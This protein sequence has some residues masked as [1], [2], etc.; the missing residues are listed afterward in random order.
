M[1]KKYQTKMGEKMG[2]SVKEIVNLNFLAVSK[3]RMYI[4]RTYD[5]IKSNLYNGEQTYPLKQAGGSYTH[6]TH[7]SIHEVKPKL[8]WTVIQGYIRICTD[9]PHKKRR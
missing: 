3:R 2:D 7:G 9:N 4:Q 1:C 5:D 6:Y 8:R